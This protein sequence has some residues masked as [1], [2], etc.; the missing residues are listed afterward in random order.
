MPPAT[1]PTANPA[2]GRTRRCRNRRSSRDGSPGTARTRRATPPPPVRRSSPAA[3]RART[4]APRCR[5]R[6]RVPRWRAA[7]KSS[8]AAPRWHER[9][10]PPPPAP[11]GWLHPTHRRRRRRSPRPPPPRSRPATAAPPDRTRRPPAPPPPPAAT[12]PPAAP[13]APPPPA[14]PPTPPAARPRSPVGDRPRSAAPP[15]HSPQRRRRRSVMPKT[16]EDGFS[17]SPVGQPIRIGHHRSHSRG[18]IARGWLAPETWHCLRSRPPSAELLRR[19][20]GVAPH[21]RIRHLGHGRYP[22][23]RHCT[24]IVDT[25]SRITQFRHSTSPCSPGG[26]TTLPSHA[27]P[28]T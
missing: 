20:G 12:P 21:G 28:A 11:P 19:V 4:D 10:R 1:A 9:T 25:T 22:I 5:I 24:A 6:W 18:R 13:A 27:S 17:A 8:R 15:A 23:H 16:H 2:P 26:A 7:A 14:P 3:P